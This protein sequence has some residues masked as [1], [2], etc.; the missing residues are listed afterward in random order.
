MAAGA[1]TTRPA[2]SS[3]A[4]AIATITTKA[5][6][7]ASPMFE[8][9]PRSPDDIAAWFRPG[10]LIMVAEGLWALSRAKIAKGGEGGSQFS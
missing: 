2:T 4:P 9:E 10:R 7:I 8:T 5:L 3:D 1:H 6:P